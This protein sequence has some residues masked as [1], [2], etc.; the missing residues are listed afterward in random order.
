[1]LNYRHTEMWKHGYMGKSLGYVDIQQYTGC[2]KSIPPPPTEYMRNGTIVLCMACDNTLR[3]RLKATK[4][5][6][7]TV[8]NIVNSLILKYQVR[9]V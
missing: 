7:I 3:C 9:C 5:L 4:Y 1:M 2:F 8:F 6:H